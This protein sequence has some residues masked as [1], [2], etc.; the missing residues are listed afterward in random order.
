MLFINY[1]RILHDFIY[2][3]VLM[4]SL[5][6]LKVVRNIVKVASIDVYYKKL[7]NQ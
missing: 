4:A 7:R 6:S 1:N 3:D 2:Y 5:S